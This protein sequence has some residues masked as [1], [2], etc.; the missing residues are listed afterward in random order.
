MVHFVHQVQPYNGIITEV[1]SA[2]LLCNCIGFY[3]FNYKC[4]HRDI[5]TLMFPSEVFLVVLS[6]FKL[7]QRNHTKK[8]VLSILIS[9]T[10]Q[11][12]VIFFQYVY[13]DLY[14]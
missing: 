1:C 14:H 10:F 3:D 13:E 7:P 9:Q 11:H 2:L 8:K 6:T 12:D 5:V 4:F